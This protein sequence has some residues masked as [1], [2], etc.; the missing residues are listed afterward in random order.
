MSN[1]ITAQ[2]DDADVPLQLVVNKNGGVAGL[3]AVVAIRDARTDDSYLDFDD[4]TF[5]TV[6]WVQRQAPLTD[7]ADGRYVRRLDLSAITNLN[8]N[9]T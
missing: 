7:L 6:G 4:D 1:Q 2:R 8:A 5:K 3:T 9:I